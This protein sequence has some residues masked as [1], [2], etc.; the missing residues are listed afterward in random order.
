M[1]IRYKFSGHQTFPFRYGWLEKG[2]RGLSDCP[3][4]FSREDAL[5]H[6]GVG[7]NMVKSIRH[8]C[9]VTQ[10]IENVQDSGGTS[11]SRFRPTKLAKCLLVD[12]QWDPFL[13]N[14]AS[15]WLIH[16]LLV[17]NP[18]VGT[19]WRL[20][21]SQFNRP[22]FTRQEFLDY[23]RQFTVKEGLKVRDSVLSRD[24][25]CLLRTYVTGSN[26]NKTTVPEDAFGSPLAQLHLIQTTPEGEF[27]RFAVGQKPTLPSAV[28]AFALHEQFEGR[29]SGAKAMSIQDSLYGEASPGQVFKLD[30]NSLYEYLED[31]EESLGGCVVLDETAGL[32]QIFRR[33]SYDPLNVLRDYYRGGD[34][35]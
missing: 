16:W 35:E 18:V 24:V 13:E 34:W 3:D 17:T 7:K 26:E 30:E 22:D 32:R 33:K 9:E 21:F 6:L 4:L 14:D 5:V 15:L 20:L 10:L 29:G 11:R 8:W 2:V 31:M 1:T 27:F 28:F 23:V 19:T 25:D 12:E